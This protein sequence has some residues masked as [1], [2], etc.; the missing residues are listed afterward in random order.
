W[1]REDIT[2][3]CFRPDIDVE[4]WLAL[5]SRVFAGHP[6]QSRFSREDLQ[7]RLRTRWFDPEDFLLAR[8]LAGRLIGYCWLKVEPDAG[9]ESLGEVYILGVDPGRSGEG[10]GRELLRAG[11]ARLHLGGI[12]TVFLYVEA[13]NP[14]AASLYRSLEFTDHSIDVQY[15]SLA[16][17]S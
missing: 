1:S 4:E 10:L 11:L 8:D 13:D 3:T 17:V 2:L 5:H 7:A 15:R 16:T 14:T 6:E 9:P 12:R